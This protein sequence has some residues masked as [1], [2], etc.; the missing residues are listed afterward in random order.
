MPAQPRTSAG[1]GRP[2]RRPDR[3]PA[4]SAP[5]PR[6]ERG[7]GC[8]ASAS[9]RQA[10]R[11]AVA[12][13]H[14]RRARSGPGPRS[15]R[16]TRARRRGP[17]RRAGAARPTSWSGSDSRDDLTEAERKELGTGGAVGQRTD[18]IMLLHTGDG[19]NLLM[20]IPRD[21]IVD[22]PGHG[23]SNKINAAF[24][25]GGPQLLVRTIEQSTGIRIDDYV[26]IGF[27][28]FVGMVDAV[29]GVEICPKTD[30]EGPRT[31]TSTSRRAARRSTARPP[32]ATPAP[33]R[34][35]RARR[36]R[37]G[38]APARGRL[39]D[40]RAR[41]S[42]RGRSSTRSATTSSARR[43]PSRS[44][45]S[46]GTGPFSL[47]RFAFAMTRVDGDEG[48]DLRR[49]D[50][51]TSPSPGTASGS[52]SC[53]STSSRTTPTS[54]PDNLCTPTG[55]PAM[56]TDWT[57]PSTRRRSTTTASRR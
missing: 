14:D 47:G 51:A 5:P 42:R 31:P 2:P 54:I 9:A 33:A 8:R 49:A 12:G 29:G 21:S 3:A 56:T 32:W 37:P 46:E 52:R 39:G 17:A 25:Y 30:D 20:S 48:P 1:D 38:P 53:S 16:S 6:P 26:E 50:P 34:H 13:L 23:D 35:V 18:T 4:P 55:M 27:G 40:R 44:R 41:R 36:H 45:S 10:A 15:T 28:G 24:A 19:P 43:P 22:D 57:R 11:P 7:G